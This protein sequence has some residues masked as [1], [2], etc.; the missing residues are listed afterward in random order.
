VPDFD[1]IV[2]GGGIA[3]ASIGYE[4]AADRRVVLLET[5][6]TLGYHTTG[7]SAAMFLESYGGPA[8]RALTVASRAFLE[9]LGV[10]TPLPM[11]YIGRAGYAAA[12]EQLH[13][14]VRALAPSVQLLDEPAAREVQPLLRPGAVER[15]LL[16]PGA[17]EI[18]VH[19]LHQHYVRGLRERGGVIRTG[20]R[21]AAAEL[22]NGLWQVTAGAD[23]WA[24]PVVVNAA[25]AWADQVAALFGAHGSGLRA[26]RRTAF[27][28]D[29]PPHVRPPLVSDVVDAFYVKP[30]TGR[31]LCSPADETPQPPADARA[32]EVEIA[33]AIELINEVTTLDV[34]HVRGRWAGLRTF[35]ADREPVV[36]Y[37]AARPGL[38]WFAGQGG[39][40]IQMAAALAR[41]GAAL[42]RD[43]AL[44]DDVTALGL[45]AAAIS[46][47]RAALHLQR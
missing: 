32:D 3:G 28:A 18:D 21:V 27:V 22:R 24:A 23:R 2:I 6:A 41:A 45:S 17:T 10:L 9:E 26:L 5:E 20:A 13:D 11:L 37:D 35:A 42:V 47:E 4:L 30:E 36:G 14:A 15:A 19:A 12:V 31:V 29:A 44:P 7:R 25:G 16:E 1:A 34:R 40:G 8:V 38:F 33:R 46:P 43:E 39:Y